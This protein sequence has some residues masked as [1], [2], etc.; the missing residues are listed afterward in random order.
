M[1]QWMSFLWQTVCVRMRRNDYV[2]L[3]RPFV[4]EVESERKVS[5]RKHGSSKSMKNIDRLL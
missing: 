4:V 1:N 2:A 3:K 5:L